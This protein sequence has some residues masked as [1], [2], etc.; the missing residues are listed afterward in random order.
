MQNNMKTEEWSFISLLT[1]YDN[2][3]RKLNVAYNH[4]VLGVLSLQS[5]H[6]KVKPWNCLATWARQYNVTQIKTRKIIN[7]VYV[8]EYLYFLQK[9]TSPL[10]TF[11]PHLLGIE[12]QNGL[13]SH[14]PRCRKLNLLHV[15]ESKWSRK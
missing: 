6:S 3:M 2:V 9:W 15:Q 11:I 4:S 5:L 12:Q 8:Y 10:I 14:T 7:L 13:A 1:F